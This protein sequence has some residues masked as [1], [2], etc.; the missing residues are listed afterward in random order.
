MT[1]YHPCIGCTERND[2]DIK[3]SVVAA[4]RGQ[5]VTLARIKC[6][7]PF[8]KFFPPGTRVTAMVWDHS[9]DRDHDGELRGRHVPSTVI[10]PATK[11]RGKLLL[12]LDTPIWFG[13]ESEHEFVAAWPKEVVKLDEP[14]AEL[15]DSCLRPLINGDCGACRQRE[16][17]DARRYG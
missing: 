7:L 12:H 6:A 3:R 13:D 4:M 5:S 11:K 10:G 14:L 15:C 9:W 2:C 1:V 17:D 16:I 8:T